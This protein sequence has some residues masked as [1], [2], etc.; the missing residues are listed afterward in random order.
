M[1]CAVVSGAKGSHQ[2]TDLFS[3]TVT[4]NWANATPMRN[5]DYQAYVQGQEESAD[6]Y[7]YGATPAEALEQ[8][9]NVIVEHVDDYLYDMREASLWPAEAIDEAFVSI[10][11]L[12]Y[13]PY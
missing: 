8:L 1:S 2:V 12:A 13:L 10:D 5:Y 4:R 6:L 11:G 3:I 9:G 7:G